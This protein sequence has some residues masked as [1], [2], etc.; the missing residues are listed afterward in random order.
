MRVTFL[1]A[2]KNEYKSRRN[3]VE[4][5]EFHFSV[6]VAREFCGTVFDYTGLLVS[7]DNSEVTTPRVPAVAAARYVPDTY[8]LTSD[9]IP[10]NL[11]SAWA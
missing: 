10:E 7:L 9:P 1:I 3:V 2:T 8:P 5:L 4:W 11:C 6:I